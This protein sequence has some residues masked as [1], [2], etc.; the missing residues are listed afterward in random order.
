MIVISYWAKKKKKKCIWALLGHKHGGSTTGTCNSEPALLEDQ[1][2]CV[3]SWGEPFCSHPCNTNQFFMSGR[4]ISKR[5]RSY[6]EVDS[7]PLLHRTVTSVKAA[8]SS[9]MNPPSVPTAFIRPSS[10]RQRDPSLILQFP[11]KV[12]QYELRI[13]AQ[14]EEQHRARYLT[15][16][17]RG[18]V[19]DRSGQGYP[20]I[21]VR[22]LVSKRK[23][24][25]FIFVCMRPSV[26]PSVPCVWFFFFG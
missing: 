8:D 23:W 17:S 12:G 22:F 11:S 13:L 16:G 15:E 3:A 25:T 20:I 9:K 6:N 4:W 1:S 14:P 21:K 24:G 10:R 26:C 18:A 2:S 7:G 5:K 19:K